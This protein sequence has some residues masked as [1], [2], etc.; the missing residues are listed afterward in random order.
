MPIFEEHGAFNHGVA[1]FCL[2]IY[3]FIIFA[4]KSHRAEE[5]KK[6]EQ[7]RWEEQGFLQ[8]EM[9][10]VLRFY[11]PFNNVSVT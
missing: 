10:V 6:K 7:C 9:L 8:S 2:T 1:K 11:G 5:R 3:V 4:R